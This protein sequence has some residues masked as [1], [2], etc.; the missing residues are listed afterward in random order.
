V[1]TVRNDA[2]PHNSDEQSG[3]H[4]LTFFFVT[5][6]ALT[7]YFRPHEFY[8]TTPIVNSLPMVTA[9]GALISFFTNELLH[10]RI[11]GIWSVEVKCLF[12]MGGFALL[13]IPLARDP[14]LAWAKFNELLVPLLLV[15]FVTVNVLTSLSRIRILMYSGVAI[16]IYLSY[17]TYDLYSRGIFEI[18]GY[19]VVVDY[20]G[21]FGNPNDMS[22]H[23]V[24]FA[25]IAIGLAFWTKNIFFRLLLMIGAFLMLVAITITQSRSGLIGIAT[26]S[27]ALISRLGRGRMV[28]AL[29][30]TS[31]AL[32]L[33]LFLAPGNIGNRIVSIFDS[34]LDTSGSYSQR[35]DALTRSLVATIRNPLGVGLG[36]SVSFGPMNLET[37]NA[38][39]QVSSELGLIGFTAYLIMILYPLRTL[40]RLE[41]ELFPNA[42]SDRIYYLVVT[43]WAAILGY[44]V[45]SFFASVA[46]LWFIY[47]P[48]AFAVGLRTIISARSQD[49]E[50]ETT[51]RDKLLDMKNGRYARDIRN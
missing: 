15:F 25:P 13:T 3:G 34:T 33:L 46:Y 32:I 40:S 7:V 1:E 45:T 27:I 18:E 2:G 26:I 35:Q 23:L 6:F 43:T 24:M 5:A 50:P 48:I 30:V 14:I 29:G 19:R 4:S 38:Y 41:K 20:G 42:N 37:H 47:Y 9:I 10:G 11:I 36:N 44:L 8:P 51:G 39:T 49:L 28:K 31:V 17:Q 16:G 21:M 12:M 22:L